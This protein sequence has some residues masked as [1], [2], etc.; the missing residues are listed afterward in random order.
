MN[1]ITRFTV[2]FSRRNKSRKKQ[3]QLLLTLTFS[4]LKVWRPYATPFVSYCI[5]TYIFVSKIRQFTP[6]IL[7]HLSL[8]RFP[9]L[10]CRAE[11]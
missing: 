3:S 8:C 5:F 6:D 7:H 10:E 11:I 2:L 9:P 4:V 1:I